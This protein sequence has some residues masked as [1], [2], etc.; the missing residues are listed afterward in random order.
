MGKTILLAG[1]SHSDIPLIQ[2]AKSMGYRVIRDSNYASG[3]FIIF[4]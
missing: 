3:L 1:G 2:A 4:D